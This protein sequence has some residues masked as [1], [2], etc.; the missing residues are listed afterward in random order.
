VLRNAGELYSYYEIRLQPQSA[1]L[2]RGDLSP[3]QFFDLLLEH[4]QLLDARSVLAHAMGRQRALWWGCLCAWERYRPEPAQDETGL[5][6]SVGRLILDPGEA[7][8]RELE[9]LLPAWLPGT[10]GGML[11]MAAVFGG[12]SVSLPNAP[13]VPPR[14]FVTGR[15]VSVAVYLAAVFGDPLPYEERLRH[16]LD[17]G[18]DIALGRRL[19]NSAATSLGEQWDA[20]LDERVATAA[21]DDFGGAEVEAAPIVGPGRS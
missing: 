15:L 3:R 11:A 6:E 7:R 5:L 4:G 10:P 12:G 8:R 16:F 1:A 17:L 20:A 21:A 13:F 14:P 19:W 18:L 9:A 2:L